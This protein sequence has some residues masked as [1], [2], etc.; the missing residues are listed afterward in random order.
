MTASGSLIPLMLNVSHQIRGDQT[1][2]VANLH[3]MTNMVAQQEMVVRASAEATRLLRAMKDPMV[4]SD[5]AGTI[6]KF[7]D[8]AAA[9]F[10][11]GAADRARSYSSPG[12]EA[13]EA[14]GKN[15][16]VL[17]APPLASGAHTVFRWPRTCAPNT[18]VLST[19][20]TKRA[21]GGWWARRAE[22]SRLASAPLH[23]TLTLLSTGRAPQ[24]RPAEDPPLHHACRCGRADALY[25]QPARR[26]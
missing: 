6:E 23:T 2:F 9:L 13:H 21:K 25:G 24:W 18:R 19:S 1:V 22:K 5:S 15:V 3:D 14:I 26:E 10:G 20:T 12:L 16:A 17:V 7:N 4:V 8:A 11:K